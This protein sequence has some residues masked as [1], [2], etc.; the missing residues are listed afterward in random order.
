PA[1]S[2]PTA[3]TV[4]PARSASVTSLVASGVA[5]TICRPL[6]AIQVSTSA[7][8][9]DATGTEKT[10]PLLART[11]FGLPQSVMGSAAMTAA[12]PAAPGVRGTGPRLQGF[13]RPAQARI[14][15]LGPGSRWARLVSTAGTTASQP[16][17]PS[18]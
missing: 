2:A 5:A 17:G 4:G 18:R 3:I 12:T 11:T 16:S 7:L 15:G 13:S 1:C 14:S 9:A 10:V 8:R 6:A